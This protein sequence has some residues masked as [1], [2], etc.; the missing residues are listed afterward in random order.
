M[1]ASI[2]LAE[3]FPTWL[4][5]NLADGVPTKAQGFCFNLS[6]VDCNSEWAMDLVYSDWFDPENPDWA[7]NDI[8]T[9]ESVETSILEWQQVASWEEVLGQVTELVK[10]YLA[11]QPQAVGLLRL[12]GGAVGFIDGDLHIV[13]R[14]G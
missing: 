8:D 10:D 11:N 3:S 5:R 9:I 1:A 12:Q 13:H 14:A 7:C 2:E 6:Q 4:D